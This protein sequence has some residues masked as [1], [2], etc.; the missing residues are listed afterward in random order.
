[1]KKIAVEIHNIALQRKIGTRI[2][3]LSPP[4]PFLSS[5]TEYRSFENRFMER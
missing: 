4:C 1:M 5:R 2:K 3:K